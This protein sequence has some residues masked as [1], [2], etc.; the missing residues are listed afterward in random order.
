MLKAWFYKCQQNNESMYLFRKWSISQ[1][2]STRALKGQSLVD[3]IKRDF[4]DSVKNVPFC[5]SVVR[6]YEAND[7]TFQDYVQ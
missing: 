6:K 2:L 4:Q 3:Y 5:R 1:A 7:Q